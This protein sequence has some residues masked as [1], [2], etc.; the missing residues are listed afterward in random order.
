MDIQKLI[1][2][3]REIE[4]EISILNKKLRDFN[5]E[6]KNVNQLIFKNCKHNWVKDYNYYSYDERPNRCTICNMVKN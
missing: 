6:L 3:R 1:S 5:K 2:D 4:K